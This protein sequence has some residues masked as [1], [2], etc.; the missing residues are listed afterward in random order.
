MK[1][2][3]DTDFAA[4]NGPKAANWMLKFR[5]MAD[6]AF[7]GKGNQARLLA[8]LL[9]LEPYVHTLR[10]GLEARG[11]AL[12]DM[13]Q[14]VL[15]LLWRC[16]WEEENAPDFEALANNFYA[17]TLRYNVGEEITNAQADFSKTR[18]QDVGE[19]ICEWAVLTWLSILLM[20]MLADMGGQLDFEEFEE[21]QAPIGF[22][23]METRLNALADACIVF[24]NTP[25]PSDGAGD[26]LKALELVY[27][28][29]LFRELAAL[30]QKC[31][32]TALSAAP[33]QYK[34]LREEYRQY[35]IL[36][37]A[38]AGDLLGF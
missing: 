28:T 27:Q 12:P 7:A 25:C 6:A 3:L 34:A 1:Y 35:T 26:T 30:I 33:E 10:Q 24:T 23:E 2:T 14:Q 18:F 11:R 5:D 38:Y 31:L 37:A 20:E 19:T 13:V 36:P 9:V 8:N 17:A 15:D 32:K 22:L 21:Y 4:L 16:L 29:P